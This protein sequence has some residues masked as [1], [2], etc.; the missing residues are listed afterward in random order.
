MVY[1]MTDVHIVRNSLFKVCFFIQANLKL[2]YGSHFYRMK[3]NDNNIGYVQKL[4]SELV[5]SGILV[6]DI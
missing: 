1:R 2:N 4:P 6:F 5:V 3:T